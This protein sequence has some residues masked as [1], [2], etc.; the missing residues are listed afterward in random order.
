MRKVQQ[1]G[2]ASAPQA[3]RTSASVDDPTGRLPKLDPKQ[4]E[5]SAAYARILEEQSRASAFSYPVASWLDA[6]LRRLSASIGV[7]GESPEGVWLD[8]DIVE[9]AKNVFR[10]TSDLLPGEPHLSSSRQGN[11]VADFTS[12]HGMMCMVVSLDSVLLYAAVG[13]QESTQALRY[14][15]MSTDA[16]RGAL[17]GF[18][19]QGGVSE[20]GSM[21]T[22]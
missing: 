16:L 8:R 2:S 3:Q 14:N 12:T 15:D 5:A 1:T 6:V 18:F 20:H 17:S 21:G 7:T 11:L 13:D 10:V 9:N 22:R 4:F 19:T